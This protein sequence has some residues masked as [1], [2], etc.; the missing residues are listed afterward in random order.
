MDALT[1]L[2]I[3]GLALSAVLLAMACVKS[4]RV[5]AWRT[6]INPSA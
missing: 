6:G 3:I 4:D 2:N 5:R 1:E